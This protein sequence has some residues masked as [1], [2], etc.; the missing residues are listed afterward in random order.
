[1]GYACTPLFPF[2]VH[3]PKDVTPE[4]ASD[5]GARSIEHTESLLGSVIYEEQETT[6]EK[7]TDS[8]LHR[9]Y[10]EYGQQLAARIAKN[11]NFY[12]PTLISLYRVKSTDYEKMLAPKLLPLV[13]ELYLA[14]VPLLTGS[15]FADKD[16][17]IRPG[18]DL[19]D[20]LVLK[21]ADLVLLNENPLK[22]IR[23]TRKIYA[24][25]LNGRYFSARKLHAMLQ[26]GRNKQ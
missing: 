13:K 9:L 25:I 17:G 4:E 22:N 15:D 2:S 19:H 1:M 14:G 7:L 6:R 26:L 3:L 18:I 16:A 21:I 8:A 5:A 24:V 11:K 10:G 20:E 12:D 23:N